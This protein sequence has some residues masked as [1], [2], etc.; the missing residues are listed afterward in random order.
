MANSKLYVD[1]M[2]VRVVFKS[3]GIQIFDDSNICFTS[4]MIWT[5]LWWKYKEKEGAEINTSKIVCKYSQVCWTIIL[6]LKPE[7]C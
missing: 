6:I 7:E 5:Q 1:S 3:G 4:F 2:K